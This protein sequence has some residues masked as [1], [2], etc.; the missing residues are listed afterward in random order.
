MEILGID[1]GGTGIK[2]APVETDTGELLAPRQRLIT[3]EGA[4]PRPVAETVA[5]VSRFFDWHG[6]IGCGFPAVVR[7]GLVRS[8]AN[9]NKKWINVDAAALFSETTGCPTFVL[10]DA[11]AAGLAEMTFGA[12]Q[13]R[14]GLVLAVTIGTGLGTALFID[15]HLVPN[16]ELGH[17]EID[18]LDA[19]RRASDMA[20]KLE[21]LSWKKWAER[22]DVYLHRLEQLIWPDLFILGGGV[23]KNHEKFIPLLT[24]E[25]DVLPA[26]LLNEAGTIGAALAARQ[27]F[28]LG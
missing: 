24:V 18:C 27:Q 13:G 16:M 8:A 6:P 11:D 5:E 19:E 12:G 20:R 9:I 4:R 25:A 14:Q 23:I 21:K 3:P 28:A 17:I 15:G 22:L 10:N 26:G 2:G 7:K 1:I